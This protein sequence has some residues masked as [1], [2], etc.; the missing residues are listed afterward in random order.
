MLV[1]GVTS[2]LP[3]AVASQYGVGGGEGR[4]GEGRSGSTFP[5]VWSV[6]FS[7]LFTNII[8]EPVNIS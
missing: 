7:V 8:N 5:D 4:G 3:H 1:K 2:L 6:A